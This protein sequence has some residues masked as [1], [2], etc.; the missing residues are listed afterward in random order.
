M[1][2]CPETSAMWNVF[3][4]RV[5][6]MFGNFMQLIICIIIYGCIIGSQKVGQKLTSI[7]E[8]Y[9]IYN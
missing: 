3:I 7:E 9:M 6:A 8:T 1:R 4:P 2:L 5:G